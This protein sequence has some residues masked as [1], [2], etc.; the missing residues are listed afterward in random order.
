MGIITG[1]RKQPAF[2][3]IRNVLLISIDTCRADHLSCYGHTGK[4]TPNIDAVA[5]EGILYENVITTVPLTLPAHSSMLTGTIPPYHGVHDNSDYRLDESHTTLA[6]VLA[7]NGFTTGAVI[8]AFVLE[9]RFGLDQGFATYY[10][11]FDE[12]S[13]RSTKT[14]IAEITGG[15]TTEHA[16]AWLDENGG[17]KFFL[18]LHYYDPHIEWDPPEPFKSS[19]PSNPY[20]GEIA[21]VDHCIGR[22]IDTLKSLGLY[23]STLIII[24]SDHGE[25][26][27]EHGELTHGY[28]IYQ[29]TLQ[30]P[31]I[32]KVPT[33]PKGLRV[34]GMAG[35]IDILPT[36][37]SLLGIQAPPG[38]QG[39]NISGYF[40]DKDLSKKERIFYCESLLPTTYDANPLVGIIQKD[41]KYI[42]TTRPELYDLTNDPKELSN[43]ATQQP[44]RARIMQDK[45]QQTLETQLTA[46]L[47]GS[48]VVLD[49]ESIARLESLGYIAGTSVDD[50]FEFDQNKDDPKD[51]LD[52]HMLLSEAKE[53]IEKRKYSEVRETCRKVLKLK[54][55]N[56]MAYH[57]LGKSYYNEGL[58][59]EAFEY[60]TKHVK[61]K[62]ESYGGYNN[63]GL[64]LAMQ[65]RFDEAIENFSQS[66][67]ISPYLLPEPY[68]NLAHALR[69]L[70]RFEEA[71]R[72]LQK[73]REI[74]P[75]V[76][77]VEEELK[78]VLAEK[79]KFDRAA[80]E[81]KNNPD[82]A[83]AHYEMARFFYKYKRLD[84]AVEHCQ[85]A[86]RIKP[87][88]FKARK[89]LAGT[90]FELDRRKSALKQYYLLL[91][92]EP[93]SAK[94]LNPIAWILATTE[95][96]NIKNP[97]EAVKFALRACEL[98]GYND[99]QTIDTLA[100]AYAADGKFAQ[101]IETAKKAIELANSLERKDL[102]EETREKL[103]L[104]KQGQPYNEP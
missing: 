94:I 12:Q 21:Y 95:D 97:P 22:V 27:K 69:K 50:S 70:G 43:L 72:Q 30:V 79:E 49:A 19:Y 90:L 17:D 32:F 92:D 44:Q 3:G 33:G 9:S 59:N 1:C 51:L 26:L 34:T 65:N 38:I 93:D 62:P 77:E 87:D 102:A 40:T 31:L 88:Y 96:T 71:L 20:T 86:L 84:L 68:Y 67:H 10:D 23:D 53:N 80:E 73:A 58:Y 66:I 46:K 56:A 89:S 42:Q 25:S 35:L 78:K 41:H 4:T 99:P 91:R 75:D 11:Q 8:S 74:F 39:K 15:Q 13:R 83:E 36:V 16:I 76:K 24:T 29:S 100:A 52:I 48:K 28:F 5:Q 47:T 82:S 104:Y 103:E 63:L 61:L 85:K 81:L 14:G 18:F 6:E 37:C 54:P 60:Y 101:A 2:K 7:Q 57:F 98:T 64:S 55:E 45:L